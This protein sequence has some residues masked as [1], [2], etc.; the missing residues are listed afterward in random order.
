MVNK[1][2]IKFNDNL[3]SF[4]GKYIGNMICMYMLMCEVLKIE[5]DSFTRDSNYVVYAF[6]FSREVSNVFGT[7]Y[8]KIN[9]IY[10]FDVIET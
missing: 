7:K 9:N 10:S 3:F 2:V 8:T 4:F 1:F 6:H 5:S